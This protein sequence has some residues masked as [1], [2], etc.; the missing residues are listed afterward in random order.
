MRS[1]S[2]SRAGCGSAARTSWPA[3][4]AIPAGCTKSG[5]KSASRQPSQGLG[6]FNERHPRPAPDRI[7][8][9]LHRRI[10]PRRPDSSPELAALVCS[11]PSAGGNQEQTQNFRSTVAANRGM[12]PLR[13]RRSQVRVRRERSLPRT[14]LPDEI[15]P[16]APTSSPTT[17]PLRARHSL[18]SAIMQ[19]GEAW[20]RPLDN[21]WYVQS[22]ERPSVLEKRLKDHISTVRTAC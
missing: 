10:P 2:G 20:A 22:T 15:P 6:V 16:C 13:S 11:T 1:T 21:T 5:R 3:T 17:S 4:A 19:L 7:D 14:S 9:G 18:A 8:F 12:F